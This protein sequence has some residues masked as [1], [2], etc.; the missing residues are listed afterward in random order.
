[1]LEQGSIN[2]AF[3]YIEQ[4]LKKLPATLY[5]HNWAHTNHVFNISSEI[6]HAN[7]F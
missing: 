2:Y 7:N 4:L 3:N 6:G 1:M 5:F